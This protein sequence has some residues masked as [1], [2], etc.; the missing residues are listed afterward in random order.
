MNILHIA[1]PGKDGVFTYY[2][3]LCRAQI[4]E[5][6]T[7]HLFYSSQRGSQGLRDL[8][9]HISDH[10]GL[11]YDM[12]VG[13]LPH[14]RD[15]IARRALRNAVI[16]RGVDA[17]HAHSSKA[18]GIARLKPL[19]C[20]VLYTPNAYFGMGRSG[21]VASSFNYLERKLAPRGATLHVSQDEADFA[22]SIGAR[23]AQSFL[24]PNPV[25]TSRFCPPS[26]EQ[27]RQLRDEL[28]IP[29]DAHVVL[30]MGRLSYQKNPLLL[31]KALD[32]LMVKDPKLFFVHVGEGELR[33]TL[34]DYLHAS[35]WGHRAL[36]I[37]RTSTPESMYRL[38]D[39][40][41]LSSRYEGLALSALE[42]LATG[43]PLAL[44]DVP[45][46]RGF[47]AM[48]FDGVS[49]CCECPTC[50]SGAISEALATASC[51]HAAQG[52]KCLSVSAIQQRIISALSSLL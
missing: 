3:T 45:G 44:T 52:V 19:P 1:E 5:G 31:Y 36:L 42:G 13:N 25:D 24:I 48:G 10:G 49:V 39:A 17:V 40:F 20:P 7:V 47:T 34:Q 37:P 46:N 8:V 14:Y 41:V 35:T 6:H 30:T 33:G 27:R 28:G 50:L 32:V 12:R 23:P 21:L 9:A 18:G 16:S 43:L 29:S 2:N 26:I 22:A 51:N 4:T 15:I 38:S 11:T